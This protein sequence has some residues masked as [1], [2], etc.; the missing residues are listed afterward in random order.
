MKEISSLPSQ[1]MR[2]LLIVAVSW[3]IVNNAEAKFS[4]KTNSKWIDCCE[5]MIIIKL[6]LSRQ[7]LVCVIS[8]IHKVNPQLIQ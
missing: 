3:L 1:V 5:F 8:F 4:Y 6:T 2:L 7:L